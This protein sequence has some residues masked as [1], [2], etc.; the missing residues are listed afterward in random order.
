MGMGGGI[1]PPPSG[2]RSAKNSPAWVGLIIFVIVIII[3]VVIVIIIITVILILILII[4]VH[5][6]LLRG[7][8][9]WK[10]D[11]CAIYLSIFDNRPFAARSH[12]IRNPTY[13]RAKECDKTPLGN[14]IKEKSHFSS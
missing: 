14:V 8:G 13:W 10:N 4:M 3:L 12:M 11:F 1:R 9:K 6:I 2:P 7:G 5:L